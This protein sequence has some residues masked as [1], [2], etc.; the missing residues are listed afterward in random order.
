M[1]NSFDASILSAIN[2]LAG[3]SAFFDQIMVYAANSNFK[4]WLFISVLLWHWFRDGD[5]AAV[6]KTRAHIVC[7]VAAGIC[8]II[9]ARALALSLPFR[10][11][12]RS[13]R[14]CISTYPLHGR[15]AI[16]LT[17]ARSRVITRSCLR[18]L[19]WAWF[20]SP[21]GSAFSPLFI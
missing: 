15:P 16:S 19:P 20:S 4:G 18:H 2:S 17:G 10:V 21:G 3:R 6:C 14:M 13:L 9:V 11:R 1:V 7:T 8:A 12:P 5:P